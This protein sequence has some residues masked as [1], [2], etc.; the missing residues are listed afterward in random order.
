MPNTAKTSN[1]V[2]SPC[3]GVCTLGPHRLCI[4]CLR[5]SEEIGRWLSYSDGERSRITAELPGRLETLFRV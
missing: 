3:V 5:S 1:P 4:G 2:Q